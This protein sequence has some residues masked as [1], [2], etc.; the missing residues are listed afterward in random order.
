MSNKPGLLTCQ[1]VDRASEAEVRAVLVEEVV[2]ILGTVLRGLRA[3][4]LSID[5]FEG[6]SDKRQTSKSGS[7][8]G[9]MT[10]QHVSFNFS[11]IAR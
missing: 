8:S 3:G 10:V 2:A 7:I 1:P 5:S 6:A 4:E 11:Y 9:N